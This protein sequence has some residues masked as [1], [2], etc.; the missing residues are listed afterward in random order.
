M[1]TRLFY[2]IGLLCLSIVVQAQQRIIGGSTANITERPY[3]VAI[4]A[5]KSNNSQ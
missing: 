4:Y 2:I 1:K 3:Q 5:N